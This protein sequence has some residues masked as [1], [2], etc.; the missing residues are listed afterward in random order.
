MIC[1]SIDVG[2]NTIR[3]SI[4]QCET[5]GIKLLLNKKTMAGLA[6]YVEDGA[7]SPKG[8]HKAC[9]VLNSYKDIV[10]NFGIEQLYV[11]ATASLRN[12]SN[13][14]EAV[15]Q[16]EQ[17]TGLAIDVI[18]G[19]EEATLDFI[20]ATRLM[21][22]D[23]GILVDIGGGSTEIVVYEDGKILK[24]TSIPIGS[25]SLFS[26][27]VGGLIPTNEER[28]EIRRAVIDELD[29]IEELRLYD[30]PVMCGVGGTIRAALKINNDKFNLS[31]GNRSIEAENIKK[32]LKCLSGSSKETLTK[33]LQVIP[34][35][36]HTIVPGMILLNTIIKYFGTETIYVSNYGVREGYLS[37]KILK[38]CEAR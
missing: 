29:K 24:A 31:A 38:E 4:Y 28:K 10:H 14:Q 15:A 20:G 1:A 6:G 17:K 30:Y 11:F 16:I 3:L 19:E 27:Y 18:T 37:Q 12:I 5:D 13:S 26:G 23:D 34:D 36:I 2:S 8:I 35:R 21:D 25:L 33:I 7:L 9:S 32:I 22:V